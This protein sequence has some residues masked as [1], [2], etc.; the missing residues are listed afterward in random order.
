MVLP[1]FASIS[2]LRARGVSIAVGSPDPSE[3][4]TRAQAAL[5]DISTLIREAAGTKWVDDS[6][7]LADV[8][9]VVFTVC[10]A[11]SKRAYENPDNIRSETYPD[12]TEVRGGDE[13]GGVCLTANEIAL[14][15]KAA[16]SISPGLWTLSTTRGVLETQDIFGLDGTPLLLATDGTEGGEPIA[17]LDPSEAPLP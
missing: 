12:Y 3:D 10:C 9:D 5:D 17:W 4:E 14:V 16:G 2:D 13:P 1:A 8:P 7:E 6:D 11:A 15:K